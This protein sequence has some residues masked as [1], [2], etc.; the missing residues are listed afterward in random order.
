[1]TDGIGIL[2]TCQTMKVCGQDSNI[3]GASNGKPN[4]TTNNTSKIKSWQPELAKVGK[5]YW[6]KQFA[7]PKTLKH[8]VSTSVFF[9][10]VG[11]LFWN[12]EFCEIIESVWKLCGPETLNTDLQKNNTSWGNKVIP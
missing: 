4:I 3:K 5:K 6:Q 10:P 2:L 11:P 1:M 8:M 7:A 12:L 9:S